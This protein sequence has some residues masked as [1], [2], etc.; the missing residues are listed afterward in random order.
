MLSQVELAPPAGHG[1]RS[2][3]TRCECSAG[4]G[5]AGCRCK[6]SRCVK[7]YCECFEFDVPCS[8]RCVCVGC[9]NGKPPA[10]VPVPTFLHQRI[11]LSCAACI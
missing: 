7:K 4:G 6:N 10:Q 2:R 8:A 11:V 1:S 3:L 9:E 5:V